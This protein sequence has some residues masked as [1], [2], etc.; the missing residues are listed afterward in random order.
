MWL[1]RIAGVLRLKWV[2]YVAILWGTSV[3]GVSL[4]SYM[5]GKEVVEK[6][7]AREINKA[8]EAQL[9]EFQRVHDADLETLV[10]SLAAEQEIK[11][12]VDEIEFPEIAPDCESAL[13]DWMRQ[14]DGAIKTANGGS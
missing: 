13:H 9:E 8:L 12:H 2:P 14:F 10:H 7:M 3:G 6:K 1:G 4:W 5:K 11:S